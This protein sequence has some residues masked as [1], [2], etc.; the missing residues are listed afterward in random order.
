MSG[1]FERF[2]EKCF[3]EAYAESYAKAYAKAR[4]E[5]RLTLIRTVIQSFGLTKEQTL[6][7][8]E[9]PVSERE[10]LLSQL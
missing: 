10:Q 4:A 7:K 5:E 3:K 6:E 2:G 9:I 8:L 1:V